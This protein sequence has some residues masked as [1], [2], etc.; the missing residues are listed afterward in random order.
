MVAAAG[1]APSF[2]P[3]DATGLMML[4][5]M[6]LLLPSVWAEGFLAGVEE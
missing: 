5:P 4:L 3:A 6:L 2:K 1:E